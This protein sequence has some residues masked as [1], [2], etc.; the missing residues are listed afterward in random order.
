MEQGE[1][2]GGSVRPSGW[3]IDRG[4]AIWC[5]GGDR[6]PSR[7]PAPPGI[8]SA[9]RWVPLGQALSWVPV[10]RCPG[11]PRTPA[12][13]RVRGRLSRSRY[14][15]GA[16][17]ARTTGGGPRPVHGEREA[18]PGARHGSAAPAVVC[19]LRR[20]ERD[21]ELP[22]NTDRD[23]CGSARI[24][25]FSSRPGKKRRSA[26]RRVGVST[27]DV[28]RCEEDHVQFK[29]EQYPFYCR[30]S[31]ANRASDPRSFTRGSRG[32]KGPHVRPRQAMWAG[33]VRPPHPP[34]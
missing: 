26:S 16:R 21:V 7:S 33:S 14:S 24:L 23:S 6:V 2:T 15:G 32:E 4:R 12:G 8:R 1:A 18:G 31:G 28:G 25:D 10:V 9:I 30:S 5:G 13:R 20:A 29:S 22:H 17:R 11:W 3:A 19:R 27:D 34:L